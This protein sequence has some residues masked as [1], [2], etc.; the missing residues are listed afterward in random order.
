MKI[1]TGML[2][3]STT[4][5][6]L[7]IIF[8]VISCNFTLAQTYKP[9]KPTTSGYA[10]VNGIKMYYEIYGEGKPLVLI[11]GGG[12]TIVTNYSNI[13]PL[14]AAN[15]KVIAVEL[16][17]HGHTTDR[18]APETFEQ[19][20]DD[21]AA[22][23]KYLKI[24]KADILGFSNGANTTIQIAARHQEVVNKLVLASGFFKRSGM[25]PQ[26]WDMLGHAELKNMPEGL[27]TTYMTI[28][29]NTIEGLTAMHNK[30]R[31]RMLAFQDW[32]DSLIKNIT[33]PTLVLAA[34][35]DVVTP[36][37]TVEMYRLLPNGKLAILPGMHGSYLGEI[38]MPDTSPEFTAATA[39]I[40]KRFLDE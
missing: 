7:I 18:N 25:I 34:D 17:A 11:H 27:K 12:S 8:F 23:L 22:L 6:Y 9:M 40:I 1:A 30:D 19:D 33:A 36:E 24:D 28:P 26:L 13:L 32:D 5:K 37:H 15:R 16:Q 35:H 21:V 20:A 2:L 10:P 39:A 14:L 4:L 29:G 31:D 3:K 38:T